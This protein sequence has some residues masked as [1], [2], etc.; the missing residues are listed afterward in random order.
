MHK[1]HANTTH[2]ALQKDIH[3]KYTQH[4]PQIT[5]VFDGRPHAIHV[6]GDITH[7]LGSVDHVIAERVGEAHHIVPGADVAVKLA[8]NAI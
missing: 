6:T 1:P 4:I 8:G 7:Q 3:I 5:T 2:N